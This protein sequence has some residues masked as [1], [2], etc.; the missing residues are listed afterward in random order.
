M[1]EDPWRVGDYAGRR[2]G[3]GDGCLGR[4]AECLTAKS[5]A[6]KLPSPD[7]VSGRASG[8]MASGAIDPIEIIKG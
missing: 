1:F 5:R 7:D 3:R 8:S 6:K 2:I 4:K